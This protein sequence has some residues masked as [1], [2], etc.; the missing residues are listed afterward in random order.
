MEATT[1]MKPKTMAELLPGLSGILTKDAL[2]TLT[3]QKQPRKTIAQTRTAEKVLKPLTIAEMRADILALKVKS[4]RRCPQNAASARKNW[5][6]S[7][8]V[9]KKISHTADGQMKNHSVRKALNFQ[10]KPKSMLNSRATIQQPTTETPRF[11]KPESRAKKSLMQARN[12]RISGICNIAET[13]VINKPVRSRMT[14]ANKENIS[15]QVNLIKKPL[16]PRK[17]FNHKKLMPPILDTPLS[18]ESWK[19]SCDASFLQNEKNINDIEMKAK[20]VSEEHTLENIAEVT[21]PVSTPFKE[22]RNVQEYFN[23]S[24]E[25]ESS[26]M[27]HDNTIMCFD[28]PTNNKQENQREESVIVSLCELLNKASVTN[29]EKASTELED[30]IEVERQTEN[31]IKMIE[32]G[33]KTLNNI[34][35]SQIKSLKYVQKLINEKRKAQTT[36]GHDKDK[37]LVDEIKIT[38]K[39]NKGSSNSSPEKSPALGKRCSVIKSCAKS[40]S[41]KIPKKNLCLRKKVF[42]KSMPNVSSGFQSPSKDIEGKALNIYMKMKEQMNFLNTPVVKHRGDRV[43]DTPAVTSHNLQRQLDKLYCGS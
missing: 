17:Q 4:P 32:N 10:P 15:N 43:P 2:Q 29:N 25:L 13:P 8:K 22:Y 27:Y 3:A 35:E 20:V 23:N 36:T 9:D 39:S 7:V 1:S 5:N 11:P 19:S 28:K 24:S 14:L 33:I 37:T 6:S 38:P 30:L 34:K 42:Y 40:P 12:V 21:P 18:N 31:N 41:Y 26:A 16:M